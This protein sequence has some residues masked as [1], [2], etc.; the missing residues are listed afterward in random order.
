MAPLG[1]AIRLLSCGIKQHPKVGQSV[2]D[3]PRELSKVFKC[4]PQL[5]KIRF[6]HSLLGHEFLLDDCWQRSRD[7]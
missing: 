3:P 4:P 1:L 5:L 2:L 7:L 6:F